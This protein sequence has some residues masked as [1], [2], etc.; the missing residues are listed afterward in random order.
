MPG[1]FR[2]SFVPIGMLLALNAVA[3][4]NPGDTAVDD[5]TV[6]SAA[7]TEPTASPTATG[8]GATELTLVAENIAF[9]PG[10]LALSGGGDVTIRFENRDAV[11]HGFSLF[12]EGSQDTEEAIFLG[13]TIGADGSTR[14]GFPA[15]EAGAYVFVCPVHPDDMV[16]TLTVG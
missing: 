11:R 14:Y 16:G 15:P 5:R 8:G 9:S 1:S 4:D 10:E 12:P 7:E 2:R 13:T 3:C 6:P